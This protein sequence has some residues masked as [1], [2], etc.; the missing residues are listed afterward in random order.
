[1]EGDI[2][3]DSNDARAEASV[4]WLLG[5]AI[6]LPFAHPVRLLAYGLPPFALLIALTVFFPGASMFSPVLIS[7]SFGLNAPEALRPLHTMAAWTIL[8]LTLVVTAF[9]LCAW[10]RDIVRRFRDPIRQLV[11]ETAGRLLEFLVAPPMLLALTPFFGF[12]FLGWLPLL[13]IAVVYAAFASYGPLVA[14]AGWKEALANG[15]KFGRDHIGGSSLIFVLFGLI[16][17]PALWLGEW[18]GVKAFVANPDQP[19]LLVADSL[20]VGFTLIVLLWLTAAPALTTRR[21]RERLSSD[22]TVFD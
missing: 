2:A 10:Q 21:E 7:S 20:N 13:T 3:D 12:T 22:P 16:W 18:I 14:V 11:A 19:S 1:M 8:L 5:W 6:L 17:M 15:W 9:L 4:V